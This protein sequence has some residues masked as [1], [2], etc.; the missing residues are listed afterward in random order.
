MAGAEGARVANVDVSE[1]SVPRLVV[2]VGESRGKSSLGVTGRGF[3]LRREKSVMHDS[4]SCADL[5]GGEANESCSREASKAS[6]PLEVVAQGG[7][8]ELVEY[9]PCGENEG[10]RNTL[11][12]M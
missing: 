2:A 7:K 1:M 12:V 4:V 9:R 6:S 11:A 5:M 3:S 8:E 10:H